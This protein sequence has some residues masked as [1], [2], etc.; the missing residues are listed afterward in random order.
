MPPDVN[1]EIIRRF[2]AVIMSGENPAAAIEIVDRHVRVH[3]PMLRDGANGLEEVASLL[4][5]FRA[6]FPNLRY[7]IDDLIADGEKVAAQWTASGTHTGDFQGI[8]PTGRAVKVI[9]TDVFDIR[10]GRIV[11]VWVNSDLFG[12]MRQIGAI[13]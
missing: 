2:F 10:D 7:E 9:G 13:R 8:A 6:A 11:E 4:M 1:K 12:L 5:T 3:H